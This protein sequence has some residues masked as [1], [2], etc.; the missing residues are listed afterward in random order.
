VSFFF[1]IFKQLHGLES[2]MPF[3]VCQSEQRLQLLVSLLGQV[4]HAH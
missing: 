2:D 1:L 4:A 3:T